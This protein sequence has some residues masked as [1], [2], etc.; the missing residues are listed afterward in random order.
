MQCSVWQ[1]CVGENLFAKLNDDKTNNDKTINVRQFT[2][3]GCQRSI[4][5][6]VLAA[7]VQDG[8]KIK[9]YTLVGNKV[10]KQY[11]NI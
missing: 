9:L 1:Y 2:V 5:L 11:H 3:S 8:S 7:Y 4:C 10:Q 6:S